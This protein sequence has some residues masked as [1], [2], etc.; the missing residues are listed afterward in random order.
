[1]RLFRQ[2]LNDDISGEA[3]TRTEAVAATNRGRSEASGA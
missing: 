2:Q 1:M 3:D